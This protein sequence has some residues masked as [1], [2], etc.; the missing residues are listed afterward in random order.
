MFFVSYF[1]C[2]NC[3]VD[4]ISSSV[5]KRTSALVLHVPGMAFAQVNK[6]DSSVSATQDFSALLVKE[7]LVHVNLALVKMVEFV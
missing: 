3:C 5:S 2:S 1:T 4:C 6:V 7:G